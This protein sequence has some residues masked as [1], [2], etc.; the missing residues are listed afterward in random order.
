[1]KN[2]YS[3]IYNSLIIVSFITFIIYYFSTGNISLG[4]L[5]TSYCLLILAIMMILNIILYNILQVSQNVGFFQSMLSFILSTGPFLLI[6]GVIGF[7]LYLLITY[8]NKILLGHVSSSYNTFNNIIVIMILLQVYLVYNNINNDNFEKN[9]HFSKVTT[10]I[11]Y[12]YGVITTI[13]SI[14]LYTILSKFSADGFQV[15]NLT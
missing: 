13:C 6:L 5:I 11:L 3:S 12:L 2:W 4:A 9:K 8:K 15:L 1:M 7:I 14:T 10:S